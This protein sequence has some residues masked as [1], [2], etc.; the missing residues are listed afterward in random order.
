MTR[1]IIK[2]LRTIYNV[3]LFISKEKN[4][5][6]N[7]I[8]IHDKLTEKEIKNIN[9]KLCNYIKIP[10]LSYKSLNDGSK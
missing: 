7:K 1:L 10:F 5:P 8:N 3:A 9:D 2:N 6:F 4:I